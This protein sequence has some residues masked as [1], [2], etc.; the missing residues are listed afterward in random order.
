MR[1]LNATAGPEIKP[2][3]WSK[4]AAAGLGAQAFA[5][6]VGEHLRLSA[7]DRAMGGEGGKEKN[8][9]EGFCFFFHLLLIPAPKL[10]MTISLMR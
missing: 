2:T 6:K 3:S 7:L 4:A 10:H 8:I 9:R 1:T 5:E